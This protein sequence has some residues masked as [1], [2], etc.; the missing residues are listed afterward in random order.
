MVSTVEKNMVD[1]NY[2]LERDLPR[3]CL[4]AAGCVGAILGF[5]G[6]IQDRRWWW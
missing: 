2:N 4:R 1:E 3:G 5:Q 6:H